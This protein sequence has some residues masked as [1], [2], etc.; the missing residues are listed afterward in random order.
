ME[1]EAAKKCECTSD[2]HVHVSYMI[3]LYVFLK[4][5]IKPANTIL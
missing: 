1:K 2:T 5:K 3:L 4:K